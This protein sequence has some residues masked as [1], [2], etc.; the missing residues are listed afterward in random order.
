M[1]T[2]LLLFILATP[3][4]SKETHTVAERIAFIRGYQCGIWNAGNMVLRYEHLPEM[5]ADKEVWFKEWYP[6]F[7]KKISHVTKEVD[8]N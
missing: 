7:V 6:F 4:F 5:P 8:K 3:V 2:A 1:K